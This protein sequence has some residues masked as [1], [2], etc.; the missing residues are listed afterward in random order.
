M[1]QFIDTLNDQILIFYETRTYQFSHPIAGPE[2]SMIIYKRINLAR[3]EPKQDKM[4]RA[5]R[6]IFHAIRRPCFE[7]RVEDTR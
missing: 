5:K 4:R 7:D 6:D 3:E 2:T 1:L